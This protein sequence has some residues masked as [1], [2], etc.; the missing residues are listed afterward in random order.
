MLTVVTTVTKQRFDKYGV[1]FHDDW[2]VKYLAGAS[3]AE[4]AEACKDADVLFVGSTDTVS[5]EVINA[6]PQLKLIQAEGV[7]FDKIDV[8]AA[9][10]LG[11]PVCNNRAVNNVSV[12]EHTVGLI[13]AGLRRTALCTREIFAKPY[14]EVQAAYRAQGENELGGKVV[15]I[16]GFGAIGR[17]V[18]K[19]LQ[20]WDCDIVY[21]EAFPP[22]K[23]VEEQLHVRFLEQD[24]LFRTADV[25]SLHV[26]VLPS[27]IGLVNK[28]SMATMKKNVLI[29]NTA[30]GEIINQE[31]LAEALEN[32]DIYGAALDVVYPEPAP[33]DLPPFHM[34]EAG[35][36]RLTFTPH[37]GGTTDEAF[38]RM[39]SWTVENCER[40]ERGE[41]PINA[42]YR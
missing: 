9:K 42:V 31:D 40:V 19:R 28:Q 2:N 8:E 10:A 4:L 18:A 17:E 29:V 41:K 35:K 3:Q 26:P 20:G 25:I 12:A 5:A 6:N 7:G 38:K 14:T 30:R 32:G 34:S 11:I 24:E 36:A 37:V 16:V 21:Y 39:L 1:A 15:G 33:A 27:T 13:L 22:S 23:E